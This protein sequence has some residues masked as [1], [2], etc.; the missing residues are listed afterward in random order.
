MP[1]P[2]A[3]PTTHVASVP[4]AVEPRR[5]QLDGLGLRYLRTGEAGPPVVLLH[6]GGID[7]AA[8]SWRAVQPAL[9]TSFRTVAPDWPGYGESDGPERGPTTEYYVDVLRR[10]LDHLGLDSVRLAGVSMGGGAALGF[11]LDSPERVD[12]LALL[13]SYGLGGGVPGGR[14][15]AW[16]AGSDPLGRL[17]WGVLRRSRRAT[18]LT[19]WAATVDPPPGLVDEVYAELQRPGATR[20]WR[21]FQRAEVRPSGLRTNYVDRLPDL[22]V[23]TLLVHGERD[24][25]VPVEWAVRAATLIPD[26]TLRVLP[27]CGHWAPRERPE[28][29]A[30]LLAEFFTG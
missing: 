12:R 6:G 2:D 28:R 26:A 13:D 3:G 22:A 18:A 16:L 4:S 20:A 11:A 25:F 10:F 14:L 24:A 8:V 29:V 7:A 21:A 23:P 9:A 30:G 5:V 19:V 15:S 17:L 27:G 1:F